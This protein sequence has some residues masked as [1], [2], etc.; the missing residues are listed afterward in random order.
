[1]YVC[2]KGK[3]IGNIEKEKM[4]EFSRKIETALKVHFPQST[5]YH[6]ACLIPSCCERMDSSCIHACDAWQS[7]NNSKFFKLVRM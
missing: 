4:K 2:L 6:S 7:V 1:M 3:K 5:F